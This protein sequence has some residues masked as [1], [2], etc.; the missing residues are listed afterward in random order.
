[1]PW[2]VTTVLLDFPEPATVSL[3]SEGAADKVV[4][5]RLNTLVLSGATLVVNA[6]GVTIG[7]D[8]ALAADRRD[9]RITSKVEN[10]GGRVNVAGFA[11]L[12]MASYSATAG[13]LSVAN[14][15]TVS[16]TGG[17]VRNGGTIE[18]N[19]T[20]RD[21]RLLFDAS[22]RF[23]SDGFAGG[24][25]TLSD[26]ARNL[27]AAGPGGKLSNVNNAISGAGR[28]S[29]ATIENEGAT[30]QHAAGSI[31]ATG[32]DNELVIETGPG[33][34]KNGGR[35][36]ASGRA[37]LTIR[38]SD[39]VV[40]T[41]MTNSGTVQVDANS[42]LVLAHLDI[43]NT[44]GAIRGKGAR[45][46]LQDTTIKG[47]SLEL[48]ARSAMV[49]TGSSVISNA[50]ANWEES[51]LTVDAGAR[52]NATGLLDQFV[53]IGGGLQVGGTVEFDFNG[54]LSLANPLRRI[55]N[56][57]NGSLSAPSLTNSQAIAG[58]G[59]IRLAQYLSNGAGASLTGNLTVIA[60][61]EVT[62]TGTMD[63]VTLKTNLVTNLHAISNARFDTPFG[64]EFG[65]RNIGT[66]TNAFFDHLRVNNTKGLIEAD[67]GE[68]TF[69][70]TEVGRGVLAGRNGGVISI[71]ADPANATKLTVDS[72]G[73][74]TRFEMDNGS[75]TSLHTV[76]GATSPLALDRVSMSLDGKTR[77]TSL[78][79]TG[80]FAL[81]G[82]TLITLS[83][84]ASNQVVL[85]GTLTN[86]DGTISGAGNITHTSA[87]TL[88]DNQAAGTIVARGK[89]ALTIDVP[90]ITNDGVLKADGS[91][92]TIVTRMDEAID[93]GG[94]VIA[95]HGGTV[96]MS[97]A[98]AFL[99][100]LQYDGRGIIKGPKVAVAG[101]ISG[102]A[103][104]ATYVFGEKSNLSGA[105]T[106]TWQEDPANTGGD[107]TI[108]SESGRH[109]ATLHLA[110][111]Y[112]SSDFA[113]NQVTFADGKHVVLNFV[114]ALT[115]A[116][117]A[118][119][120][121]YTVANWNPAG[122]YVP[123][124][125][126]HALIDAAGGK[127]A[128]RV[129]RD[130]EVR[131]VATGADATLRIEAATFTTRSGTNRIANAGQVKAE[132]GATFAIG[133]TF[134][135][136]PDGRIV[137]DG[138]DA[139]IEIRKGGSVSGGRIQTRDGGV[140]EASDGSAAV[141]GATLVNDGTID[142][143]D[144]TTL[145]LTSTHVRGAGS[146]E[147]EKG[148]TLAFVATAADD[149][150][151]AENTVELAGTL[152]LG[153]GMRL[154]GTVELVDGGSIVAGPS[155]E[156]LVN[157]GVIRG[158]GTIGNAS[159]ALRNEGTV[160]TGS[161]Q[162]AG[163]LTIATGGSFFSNDGT[164]SAREGHVLTLNAA[165]RNTDS[166]N[167]LAD[168]GRVDMKAAATNL[169]GVMQAQGVG[170]AL[171]FHSTLHNRG[172][173]AANSR[174][175]IRLRG[176]AAQEPTGEIRAHAGILDFRAGSSVSG[177]L[178]NVLGGIFEATQGGK[179]TLRETA[180]S[181]NAGGDLLVRNGTT[182]SLV[183]MVVSSKGK[184]VVEH[185]GSTLA[186]R[187]A[188]LIGGSYSVSG[189]AK[190][191]VVGRADLE[192]TRIE[193][194]GG[195]IDSEGGPA[196]LANAGFIIAG[197]A[198][199]G[200][201]NLTL[202]NDG[203]ITAGLDAWIR[204]D[205]GGNA[206]VNKDTIAASDAGSRVLIESVLDNEG[207]A[208]LLS[209]AGEVI[210][211][212]VDNAGR[213]EASGIGHIDIKG[214]LVNSGNVFAGAGG[215][216]DAQSLD[217]R[218]GR[219]IA[220]DEGSTIS[221]GRGAANSSRVV[222][223]HGGTVTFQ[224][225]V[226]NLTGGQLKAED[227]G[228]LQVFGAATGGVAEIDG[229]GS[230]VDF[231]GSATATTTTSTEFGKVGLGHLVLNNSAHFAGTVAGFAAGDTIDVR[232]VRFVVGESSYDASTRIL[233]VSDGTHIAMVQLLGQYVAADFDFAGDGHG[234][235][236]VTGS[237][238]ADPA[239]ATNMALLAAHTL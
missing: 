82:R 160:T 69:K 24:E 3:L 237:A 219:V 178:I 30:A 129:A 101:T 71:V 239:A 45:I 126:D 107:L 112:R 192:E 199:V 123:G 59:T 25:V 95:R 221:F 206:I 26:S 132:A 223:R 13:T 78:G 225:G 81:Q 49:V 231:E 106:A 224:K 53:T 180:L 167:V 39:P 20:D 42:K 90:H 96:D 124:A 7:K 100:S 108:K 147:I 146:I 128:V 155:K 11:S 31:V 35:I 18:L 226:D 68:I 208:R 216:V 194:D 22:A 73:V 48:T 162:K 28:I 212:R 229:D 175:L 182:L 125:D 210:A 140:L 6:P 29:A 2:N 142:V 56:T 115:W 121:W 63:G 55:G 196:T 150:R 169:G 195:S 60:G 70:G 66:I 76:T 157:Q 40:E 10:E 51:A 37:G 21:T 57:I 75:A 173:V 205:T 80:Q 34:L 27:I 93:G 152:K 79:M 86:V 88:L 23:S 149:A 203:T 139:T 104:G 197:N 8:G 181:I 58:T 130:T 137:A 222:A 233:K 134:A 116:R 183:D 166:G 119:G 185:Q 33:G 127:Y 117:A 32:A 176:Q 74:G 52:L 220:E 168:R 19:S 122:L 50:S 110:G 218:A 85:R 113:A 94:R 17:N 91:T 15:A 238:T 228:R 165:L 189:D 44:G 171:D 111:V 114:G 153:S 65:V 154:G 158:N 177:G 204:I 184:G 143:A 211:K 9:S 193:L 135:Q 109:F 188:T 198:T 215:R 187:N 102:F 133:G 46:D 89:N 67:D 120:N 148:S 170:G 217:N 172:V 47:G 230:V 164:L 179:V 227:G 43:N 214:D 4:I 213:I 174:G 1:V 190:L 159:L 232:D 138:S 145:T 202:S 200:D 118:S 151:I 207:T 161:G 72:I 201:A 36:E 87:E 236:L 77:A 235:T 103:T 14:S 234:G 12:R 38:G 163:S 144:K 209:G 136:A 54:G 98:Q 16:V 186:L 156:I 105:L 41:K 191:Q 84:S 97:A 99:G 141:N 83:D 62:N 92:L 5:G 64:N 61:T 131:S